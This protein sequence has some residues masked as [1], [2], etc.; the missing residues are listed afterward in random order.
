MGN[1]LLD[2]MAAIEL[3]EGCSQ[4]TLAAIDALGTMLDVR[5]GQVLCELGTRGVEFFVLLEGVVE[6]RTPAGETI[7][8]RRG[9]WFGEVALL[10]DGYRHA[11]V[12]ATADATVQVF[13]RREFDAL[14][15]V[16]PPVRRRVELTTARIVSGLAPTSEPWY[17]VLPTTA[18]TAGTPRDGRS[19]VS[20]AGAPR[21]DGTPTASDI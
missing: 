19:R 14:M 4:R 17:E 5:A 13:S 2:R 11:T 20:S 8:L 3:Y 1:R 16:A 18:R 9:A 15:R 6:V 21:V 12:V 10:D 7:R